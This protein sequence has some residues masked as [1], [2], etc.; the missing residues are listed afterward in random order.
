MKYVILIDAANYALW[1]LLLVCVCVY[2]YILMYH[3]HII[4]YFPRFAIQMYSCIVPYPYL[5]S[6]PMLHRYLAEQVLQLSTQ[7][8]EFYIT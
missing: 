6:M 1:I 4:S 7:L 8:H 3:S 2:I 5:R